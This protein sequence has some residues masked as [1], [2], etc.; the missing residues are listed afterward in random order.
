ML[1][2]AFPWKSDGVTYGNEKMENGTSFQNGLDGGQIA[3]MD[4]QCLAD[5]CDESQ[6]PE[7]RF[8]SQFGVDLDPQSSTLPECTGWYF[9]ADAALRIKYGFMRHAAQVRAMQT[10]FPWMLVGKPQSKGECSK[11]KNSWEGD[12]VKPLHRRRRNGGSNDRRLCENTKA[13]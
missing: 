2:D 5:R 3:D 7:G 13:P 6:C 12:K 1:C 4:K 10:C 11:T 9:K 8:M